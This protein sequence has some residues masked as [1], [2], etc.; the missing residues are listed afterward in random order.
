MVNIKCNIGGKSYV[1]GFLPSAFQGCCSKVL[2]NS[3][4]LT[5]TP[6]FFFPLKCFAWQLLVYSIKVW[7]WAL[8]MFALKIK[9]NKTKQQKHLPG[10]L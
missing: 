5:R 4:L 1:V 10:F 6:I 2:L 9:H 8:A 3:F 7:K